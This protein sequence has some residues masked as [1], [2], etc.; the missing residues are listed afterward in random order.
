M[1]H[2]LLQNSKQDLPWT[3]S[4]L[5]RRLLTW[6]GRHKRSLPW[7]A[8]RDP[9]RIWISEVMLQ[10]TT[11]AQVI[12]Y[13]HRFLKAFPTIRTLSRSQE[14]RVL[15][16]WEGL[17]YYRRGRD[18]L[19]AAKIIQ[20]DYGGKIPRQPEIL[21]TLPGMGRYTC[22]A[23]LS[24]AFDARLP[25]LEANSQR[26]LARLF[27]LERRL[28]DPGVRPWLW[29]KAEQI[30]PRRRVGDFN[31]ALMELGA[32]VCTPKNPGCSRCP[33]RSGCQAFQLGKAETIP[34]PPHPQKI[35]R[36]DSLAFII[37]KGAQILVAKRQD[38]GRWTN[39][40]EFPQMEFAAGSRRDAGELLASWEGLRGR[41][42]DRLFTLKQAVT[43][44]RITVFAYEVHYLSGELRS[45]Y[46]KETRWL[47]PA[48]M[49]QLPMNRTHRKMA[50][51]LRN[52]FGPSDAHRLDQGNKRL[53]GGRRGSK[54]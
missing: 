45:P 37:R 47:T 8:N 50:Q 48:D 11:V 28:G 29:Q 10:Q 14:A 41:V 36:R 32:L 34:S 51:A 6:F 52:G 33:V 53:S 5:S 38:G 40:W 30:L 24:Q 9:Y 16:L 27:G 25:I 15:R 7:R 2:K 1:G 12:P 17:G 3:K 19:A 18:L 31:Q 42:I 23:V 46:Y 26:V 13:F 21:V 4:W 43:R 49:A 44:F 35:E 20:K 54:T 22:N 39:M